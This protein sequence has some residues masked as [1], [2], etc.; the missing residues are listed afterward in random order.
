LRGH[1]APWVILSHLHVNKLFN[2][3]LHTSGMLTSIEF[4]KKW[5]ES[6]ATRAQNVHVST[7]IGS[8][9]VIEMLDVSMTANV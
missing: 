2:G 8:M 3:A 7:S 5:M 4:K 6:L 1:F 9:D